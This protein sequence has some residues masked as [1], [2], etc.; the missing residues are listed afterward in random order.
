MNR[1]LIP[2]ATVLMTLLCT[3]LT[4][5]AGSHA[6]SASADRTLSLVEGGWLRGAS[7]EISIL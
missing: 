2:L 7:V 3:T 6:A 5:A 4:L 1:A